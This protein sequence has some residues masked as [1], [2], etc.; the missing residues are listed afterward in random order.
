LANLQAAWAE[1]DFIQGMA[2]SLESER[3]YMAAVSEA[4]R[5]SNDETYGAW[6]GWKQYLPVEDADRSVWDHLPYGEEVAE[7]V[8]KQVYCR[9]WRFAWLHQDELRSL[10]ATQEVLELTRRAAVEKSLASVQ[11]SFEQQEHAFINRSRYDKLRFPQPFSDGATLPR[12]ASKA[13]RAE[14]DRSMTISAIALK[15]YSLKHGKLPDK[16]DALVPEFVSAVPVDYMDGKP[17]RYRLNADGGF[18]L[19]SV[20]EN[21]TDD[22]GDASA[23]PGYTAPRNPWF[24]KDYIWPAPATPEEVAAYHEEALKK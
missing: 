14:T 13:L 19:Y 22:A 7:F 21:L 5:Q 23:V 12:A 9:V 16:L 11:A 10:K 17:L 18:L 6:F 24:K 4:M 1:Q 3:V 2:R 8:K 15:R 20:G